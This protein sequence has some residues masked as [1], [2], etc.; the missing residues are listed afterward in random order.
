MKKVI[1]VG[2]GGKSFVMEDDAYT[3]LNRYLEKFKSHAKMGVQTKEVMDDLEGRIAELFS[4]GLNSYQDVINLAMV[5]HVISQ[6]GMPDGEPFTD[7][8]DYRRSGEQKGGYEGEFYQPDNRPVK[9]L[10]RDT[11]N[12][13]IGGVCSGLAIYFGIDTLLVRILF[14]IAF[15]LGSSGFWIYVILW[16]AVPLANTPVRKCEM[17]GLSVT[18]ENLRR[19][20]N[21]K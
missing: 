14:V 12:K 10:Y 4:E 11:V 13:S 19:F 1:N 9:R 8:D 7:G 15:F 6:L 20:T 17:Y 18:A 16:I 2:I 5:N 21:M 3:K